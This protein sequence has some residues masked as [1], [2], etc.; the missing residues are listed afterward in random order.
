[1]T[2]CLVTS[3]VHSYDDCGTLR[4]HSSLHSSAWQDVL[5]LSGWFGVRVTSQDGRTHLTGSNDR[6][7][8][9][10]QSRRV[11]PH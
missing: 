3:F 9:Q 7:P 2:C 11:I 8:V 10:E 1:M 6:D 5:V 4:F